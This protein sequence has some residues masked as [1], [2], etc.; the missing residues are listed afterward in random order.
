MKYV[1]DAHTH[2]LASGHAYSTIR[3]MAYAAAQKGLELLGITEHA[4]NLPGTCHGFYFENLKVV[5]RSMYEIELLLGVELNILDFKGRVD[6]EFNTLKKMDIGIASLHAPCIVPGT[7][8]DN[9]AAYLNAMK[10]PYV[11]IIGHPDDSRFPVYYKD[12]VLGAKENGVLLELNN[13]SLN[14]NGARLNPQENDIEMLELCK[15]YGVSIVVN[16]DSHIDTEVGNHD[17]A[18]KLLDQL[19]F[20]EELVVNRSVDEFKKYVNRYKYPRL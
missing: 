4:P 15:R 16:S 12:L 14:P 17:Q 9:T 19:D 6:L 2:T 5:E 10:N 7:M 3:E 8:E 18:Q 11:N 13:S 20:P 1:L